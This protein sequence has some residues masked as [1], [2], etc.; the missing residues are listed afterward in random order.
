MTTSPWQ[1]VEGVPADRLSALALYSPTFPHR[2]EAVLIGVGLAS[3]SLVL[4]AD[5]LLP[6]GYLL[7]AG[8]AAIS[9]VALSVSHFMQP[10]TV[11]KVHISNPHL[12]NVLAAAAW[13]LVSYETS[14]VVRR[15]ER[16]EVWKMYHELID[17]V[18]S[19]RSPETAAMLDAEMFLKMDLLD[20]QMQ[21]YVDKAHADRV[22]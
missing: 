17:V 6:E 3:V 7:W 22:R 21:A 1:A 14:R 4:F 11:R 12:E 20:W 2:R 9:A 16:R 18:A 10:V 19:P 8:F 13:L 5:T 15:G